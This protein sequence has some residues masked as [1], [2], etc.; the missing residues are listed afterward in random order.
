MLTVMIR[1]MVAVVVV[2]IL[3]MM[4]CVVVYN[5]TSIKYAK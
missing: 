1:T 5:I 2:M 3:N 4:L